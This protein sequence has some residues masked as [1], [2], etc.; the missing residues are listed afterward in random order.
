MSRK[1]RWER[2]ATTEECKRLDIRKFKKRWILREW[3][4]NTWSITFSRG[5]T[6]TGTMWYW[7]DLR[8]PARRYIR[9]GF[10]QTDRYGNKKDFNYDIRI[11]VTDCYYWWLRYWFICPNCR[12]R[13]GCL[14]LENDWYFYCRKCMN[15]GYQSQL[16]WAYSRM[17][18]IVLRPGIRDEEEAN[19]LLKTIKY[20]YRNGKPTRKLLKYRKIMRQDIP[21][22]KKKA[23]LDIFNGY[24][25]KRNAKV[26]NL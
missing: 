22:Q 10:T 12:K 24:M 2:K 13:Y 9:M 25:D 26:S 15:L 21:R 11:T 3:R 23:M 4:L 6:V 7:L 8:N 14:Y 19:E 5:D 16:E 17:L 18:D 1:A 20:P